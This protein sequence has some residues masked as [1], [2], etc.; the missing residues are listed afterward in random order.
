MSQKFAATLLPHRLQPLVARSDTPPHRSSS[1]K[2]SGAGERVSRDPFQSLP[3]NKTNMAIPKTTNVPLPRTSPR[4]FD[5]ES[6]DTRI[7]PLPPERVSTSLRAAIPPALQRGRTPSSASRLTPISPA[8]VQFTESAGHTAPAR[9]TALASARRDNLSPTHQPLTPPPSS[10]T[11][12]VSSNAM[13]PSSIHHRPSF[14]RAPSTVSTSRPSF[15]KSRPSLDKLRPS[16]DARGPSLDSHHP[17][18]GQ[19]PSAPPGAPF[20]KPSRPAAPALAPGTVPSLSSASVM[21]LPMSARQPPPPSIA[22]PYPHG[23]GGR[24]FDTKIGGE[25]GMAGVGRRGFAAAAR[26]AMFVASRPPSHQ[27]AHVMTL[28]DGHRTNVPQYLDTSVTTFG[29]V[30]RGKSFIRP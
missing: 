19:N 13:L 2:P 6:P 4:S 17:L 12:N 24:E 30:M 15:H 23:M 29:H 8:R 26:A 11:N 7:P 14:E 21:Q 28:G 20:A 10:S 25:A 27:P 5:R 1:E 9:P 22:S 3:P 16:L 18:T